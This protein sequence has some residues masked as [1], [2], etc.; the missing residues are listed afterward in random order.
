VVCVCVCTA[1]AA[2]QPC[3]QGLFLASQAEAPEEE[4]LHNTHGSGPPRIA[5]ADNHSGLLRCGALM[6]R[7][8]VPQHPPGSLA[9][10]LYAPL[11]ACVLHMSRGGS[12]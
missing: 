7:S 9:P 12:H 11:V 6:W 5:A 1:C 4:C 3:G 10:D 8:L 2:V